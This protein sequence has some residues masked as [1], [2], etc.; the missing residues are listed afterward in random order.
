[1]F[2]HVQLPLFEP[3]S[4]WVPPSS[5]PDL[6]QAKRIA[7]DT[8]TRDPGLQDRGS[9]AVRGEGYVVG[10]GVAADTGFKGYFPIAH[11]LGGNLDPTLCRAWLR[12]VT[13]RENCDYIFANAPYDL[14]WLRAT[15]VEVKGRVHDICVREALIEEEDPAGYS[16]DAI[17][18]RRLGERKCEELLYEAAKA[19]APTDRKKDK[20]SIKADL[21]KFPARLVGPYGE[22][23]PHQTLRIFVEQEKEIKRQGLEKIVDLEQRLTRILFEMHW[24]G[25]RVDLPYAEKL[26]ERWK[27]EEEDAY[28]VLGGFREI[29]SAEDCARYLR[30]QGL[31]VGKSV[32]KHLLE[33]LKHPSA[34]A[35]RKAREIERTRSTYLEQN[36]IRKSI[37]GRIHP[38]YVQIHSDEGGTRTG[39]LA[40]KNP[41]AQQFPKRST[42]FDAKAIRKCLLPE[43]G[44]LWAKLDYWSQEPTLQIHYALTL[45]LRG[46]EEARAQFEKGI[47]LAKHIANSS[48]GKLNYD[49][50]KEVGLARSYGQQLK[51]MAKKMNLPENEAQIIQSDFDNIVPFIAKLAELTKAKAEDRGFI[52]TIGGRIRH[53]NLWCKKKPRPHGVSEVEYKKIM[54]EWAKDNAPRFFEEARKHWGPNEA[55]ERFCTYKAFNALCQGGGADMTKKALVD[56]YEAGMLAQI[57]VHDEIGASVQDEK[58]ARWV[59]EIMNNVYKLALPIKTELD[60]GPSWQ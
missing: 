13:G 1:M 52:R 46:A 10:F 16:L 47:K 14:G 59:Q 51:G 55:L 4:N 36:L 21:W 48:G 60:L 27:K 9:G 58:E 11:E 57:Q 43:E 23:D 28:R 17:A 18:W 38:E 7:I 2:S 8:E 31:S 35:L 53:F 33:S 20:L 26:N 37:N 50:A 5:F 22:A 42:S 25:I 12:E 41:N 32:D 56:L 6:S 15:G 40:C 54:D 49:Q 45:G 39:R 24:R 44:K 19:Y 3:V 29:W 34:Q 30:S